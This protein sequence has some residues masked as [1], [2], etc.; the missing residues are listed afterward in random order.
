MAK[1]QAFVKKNKKKISTKE[2]WYIFFVV[3]LSVALII[4]ILLFL[5]NPLSPTYPTINQRMIGTP[6]NVTVED[7]GAFSETVLFF[8]SLLPDFEIPQD[9]TLTL[10][11]NQQNCRARIKIFMFNDQN[12]II[13]LSANFTSSWEPNADGYYYYIEE[14]TP[15]LV[16]KFL[17][18]IQ[19]PSV[20]QN[21]CS[22]SIY[23]FIIT[24][25]TLPVTADYLTLWK[26]AEV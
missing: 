11:A 15:D 7:S 16:L 6:V 19:V 18:S 23:N 24:I 10:K 4:L 12:Q 26:L 1:I 22:S 8:G 14:I 5:Y 21:L 9:A 2:S 17:N 3:S 13:N 25:E 20:E